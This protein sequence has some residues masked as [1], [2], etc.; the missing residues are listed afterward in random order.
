DV[1]S[2][3][4]TK[5]QRTKMSED[6][7]HGSV[8]AIPNRKL[9]DRT[10]ERYNYQVGRLDGRKCH[11]APFYDETG[12]I[13]AQKVRLPGKDFKV[14][15]DLKAALPL[16]G[17]QLCRDG[18]KQIVITEGEID[19]LS[20]A[21]AMGL[22]W[23]VVSVPNGAAGAHKSISRALGFLERSPDA[24]PGERCRNA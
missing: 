16:F 12:R 1:C 21:Q 14:L 6:L 22:N 8:E 15:G 10:C 13:V 4:L 24:P 23:P 17:Q 2:S 3:D 9:D 7:I 11:I 5:R 20:V 18:G 19:A